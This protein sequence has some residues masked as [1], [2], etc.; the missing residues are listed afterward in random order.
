ME[1]H[2]EAFL[3][4]FRKAIATPAQGQVWPWRLK[5]KNDEKMSSDQFT[6]G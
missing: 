2:V 3:Q 5:L 1:I 6:L 4:P